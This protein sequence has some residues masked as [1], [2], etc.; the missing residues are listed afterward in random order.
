MINLNAIE[1][2]RKKKT[3]VCKDCGVPFTVGEFSLLTKCEACLDRDQSYRER[4]IQEDQG[5]DDE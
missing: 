3:L 2:A 5:G 1:E 4:G